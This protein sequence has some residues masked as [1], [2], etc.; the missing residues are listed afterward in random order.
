[1]NNP[2]LIVDEIAVP[3][4]DFDGYHAYEDTLLDQVPMISGRIVEEVRGT[5]WRIDY[6]SGRMSDSLTRQLLAVLRARGGKTWAFLPDNEDALLSSTFLVESL[7][8]PTLAF[9]DG[10]KPVWTGLSFSLRE[11]KPHA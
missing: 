4:P 5:V 6:T 2:F 11:V 10:S 1:M 9:F 7:T 3:E 8:P